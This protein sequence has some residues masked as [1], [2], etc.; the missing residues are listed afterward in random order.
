MIADILVVDEFYNNVDQVREAALASDF[1]VK[2]NYPGQ[3]TI[4]YLN[5]SIKN[6]IQELIKPLGGQ[7]T[8][9]GTDYSGAF[10]YTT[11]NDESWIHCDHYNV[12][13]GVC[14]LTPDAPHSAGTGLFRHKE[15]GIFRRP[16]SKALED[17]LNADGNDL[18][19]WDLTDTLSNKYNRIIF[20]R[21]D[22]YHRSLD[23]FGEDKKTGRLF[24]TFFFDTEF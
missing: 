1:S 4:S 14:Y 13:A 18:S 21:G 15:T 20:Y 6:S 7:V 3:R 17:K 23:Y 9:W 8:F 19:K 24:Q 5:D 2:G 12:W 11:K 16:E 22:M 10:Q